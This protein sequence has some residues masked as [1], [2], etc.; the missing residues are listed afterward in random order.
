M[1]GGGKSADSTAGGAAV[2]FNGGSFRWCW[3]VQ[4]LLGKWKNNHSTI[5]SL[6]GVEVCWGGGLKIDLMMLNGNWLHDAH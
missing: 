4:R 2:G 3:R 5:C 1:L 6:I